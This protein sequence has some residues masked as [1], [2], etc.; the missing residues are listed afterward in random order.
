MDEKDVTKVISIVNR[1]ADIKC[2]NGLYVASCGWEDD[3]GKW[4]ILFYSINKDWQKIKEEL[5]YIDSVEIEE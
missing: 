4:F 5:V 1:Y 3:P 2:D